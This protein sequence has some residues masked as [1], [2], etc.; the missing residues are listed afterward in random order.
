MKNKWKKTE[1]FQLKNEQ[2]NLMKNKIRLLK[3]T[4]VIAVSHG[5][6]LSD[7]CFEWHNYYVFSFLN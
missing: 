5:P 4:T 2:I 1:K 6:V 3:L 7:L